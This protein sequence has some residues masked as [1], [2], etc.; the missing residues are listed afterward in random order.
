MVHYGYEI[1]KAV[2]VYRCDGLFVYK[3]AYRYK[4]DAVH[5]SFNDVFELIFF[6]GHFPAYAYFSVVA[7]SGKTHDFCRDKRPGIAYKNTIAGSIRR[8]GLYNKHV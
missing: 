2:I 7:E 3:R 5:A 6:I 8:F 4:I 1:G